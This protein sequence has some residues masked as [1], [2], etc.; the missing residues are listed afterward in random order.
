[1]SKYYFGAQVKV[2][3]R[4]VIPIYRSEREGVWTLIAFAI[5]NDSL[6][7]PV[8]GYENCMQEVMEKLQAKKPYISWQ[9]KC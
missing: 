4:L 6:V 7:I 5:I 1:M 2:N 8:C 9:L 3:N